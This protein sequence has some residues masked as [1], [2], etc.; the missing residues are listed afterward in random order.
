MNALIILRY[1]ISKGEFLRHTFLGRVQG[2][3]QNRRPYNMLLL[4]R[5]EN[6]PQFI[7]DYQ[8]NAIYFFILSSD[9]CIISCFNKN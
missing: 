4:I 1:I 6:E 3:A 5:K 7:Q 9:E 8:L 2:S